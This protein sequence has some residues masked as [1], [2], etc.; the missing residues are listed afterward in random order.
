MFSKSPKHHSNRYPGLYPQVFS[1]A[2]GQ[3]QF[4]YVFGRQSA[5]ASKKKAFPAF[6]L[7]AAPGGT[8]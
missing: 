7:M 2:A 1:G 8:L 4:F 3:G 6:F 5:P